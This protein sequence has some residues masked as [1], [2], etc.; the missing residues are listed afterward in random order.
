MWLADISMPAIHSTILV[1]VI[2]GLWCT[3]TLSI[4]AMPVQV[5]LLQTLKKAS[6]PILCTTFSLWRLSQFFLLML[7]LRETILALMVPRFISLHA[8][9]WPDLHPWNPSSM[10]TPKTL[11]RESWK[12]NYATD[13]AAQL[14]WCLLWSPWP[15]AHQLPRSLRQ[16]PQPHDCWAC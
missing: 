11:H 14:I 16:Q 13:F 1:C 3:P 2:T 12:S 5:G 9:V 15:L 6:P 8:V 4:C 7:I 10:L